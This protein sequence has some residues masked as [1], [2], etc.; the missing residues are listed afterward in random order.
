MQYRT[1]PKNGDRLSQ[2]G[3]GCLRF[4]RNGRKINQEATNELVAAAIER[5]VNFFD[6][7]Y[8]YL[9]S[10]EALGKALAACGKRDEVFIATKL[11]HF[12]CKKPDDFSK[13]LN[14]QLERLQT[15]YIDYYFIHMLSNVESWELMKSFGIEEW[16]SKERAAGKIRNVGFSFHGG[17]TSFIQLLDVY[18]WEFC[19]VQ[20]NYYDEH[21]QATVNGVREAHS[22]GLPVFAME[23][24]R[25][26][27]LADKLPDSAKRV[28][29]R[30]DK[31]LSP[32]EWAL[33][34]LFAQP[35]VTIALS[36][37]SNVKELD[38]N[39]NLADICLPGV[40]S[41]SERGAYKDAVAALKSTVRIPCTACEYCI[42]CP[43]GVDIPAC[44]AHYNESFSSGHVRAISQYI[45]N[46]GMLSA[47]QGD[48][49]KCTG[50]KKC[51]E[52]C[53]QDIKIANELRSVNRR[54]R[55]LFIK[56]LTAIARKVIRIR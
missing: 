1:N 16:L 33:K 37:M 40:L 35:E 41:E 15:D 54:M 13:I 52:N 9:G 32:A 2:L 31:N 29:H 27:L 25:G 17:R 8:I 48:A 11:P 20:Y 38:E 14:T 56:P 26:G 45:K 23:P 42:P 47:K 22:R 44:F 7:A 43:V 4:P 28:L 46:T 6:T 36:G 18:P 12:I 3:L 21:N 49:S 55:T 34:W 51:E 5:G 10:E 50:C 19:M 39:A 53:P 24:L 30:A